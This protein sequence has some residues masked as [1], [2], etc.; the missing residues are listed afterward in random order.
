MKSTQEI[1][2]YVPLPYYWRNV[3]PG[4]RGQP[5]QEDSERRRAGTHQIS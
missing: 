5:S 3:L 1:P 4:F 2:I